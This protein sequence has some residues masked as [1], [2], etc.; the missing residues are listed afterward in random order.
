[1]NSGTRRRKR[2]SAAPACASAAHHHALV[3][4]GFVAVR[5][6]AWQLRKTPGSAEEGDY[7]RGGLCPGERRS[8]RRPSGPAAK[9]WDSEPAGSGQVC[10][11]ARGRPKPRTMGAT[12][13]VLSSEG[14]WP[15]LA[16]HVCVSLS[17]RSAARP[18]ECAAAE[19]GHWGWRGN[20][21]GAKQRMAR[22][23]GKA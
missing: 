17:L 6:L 18:G 19:G 3:L 13:T 14:P 20:L 1:V 7:G 10:C 15:P 2:K 4:R 9:A 11:S 22:A 21:K 5:R 12:G 16:P 8:K 23:Q